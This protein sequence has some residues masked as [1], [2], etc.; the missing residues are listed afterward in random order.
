MTRPRSRSTFRS[1]AAP[2]AAGVLVAAAGVLARGAPAAAQACCAG[3]ALV[4]P[5]RLAPH[6]DV[7]V[8]VA[9]RAR[10]NMGF[11][12]AAGRYASSSGGEQILEQRLAA[13]IRFPEQGQASVVLPIVQTHRSASGIDEWGGGVG[14]VALTARYDFW[15]SAESLY[16]PGFALLAGVTLPTGTAPDQA[17]QPLSTDATGAGTYDFTL[18]VGIEKAYG[19]AYAALNGWLTHRTSRTVT[20]PGAAPFRESFGLRWTALA[21]GGYVFDNEA[22][23]ALYVNVL[24]EGDATINGA[25]DPST[26]IR[27]TTVGAAAILP[28]RDVWR[29]RAAFFSDVMLASFGRNQLAG[30]GLDAALVRV[31]M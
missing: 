21:T 1:G 25:G 11:F 24:G 18:G 30:M 9:A 14:D 16:R 19:H 23:L 26:G 20:F 27:L 3:G 22:A 13:S 12:D 2:V 15:L 31:W 5:A 4:S 28:V 29:V 7:G 17:M 10:S 6:E 8:G